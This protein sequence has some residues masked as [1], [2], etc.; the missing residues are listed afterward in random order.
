MIQSIADFINFMNENY[1]NRVAFRWVNYDT[2]ELI[3]KTFA[4]Y[5]ADIRRAAGHV[6]MLCPD[7]KGKHFAILAQNSYDYAV[8][9]FGI[10]LNG[11]VAVLLNPGET[12]E[13]I[14]YAAQLADTDIVLTDGSI[15]EKHPALTGNLPAK[16]Y[17]LFGYRDCEPLMSMTGK[18]A[19]GEMALIMFTSGT[20]GKC[21]GVMISRK[22]MF[23]QLDT[24][25]KINE[26][27]MRKYFASLGIEHF[28]MGMMPVSNGMFVHRMFHAAGISTLLAY[29]MFG[30]TSN[31][32][33]NL[34]YIYQ[35]LERMPCNK[36][37]AVPII[38]ELFYKD[39]ARG[40][41]QKLGILKEINCGAARIDEQVMNVFHENGFA[42]SQGYAL[43]ES[44]SGGTINPYTDITKIASVGKAGEG[45]EIRI[46]D[47]E[48]CMKGDS[49]MMGY[50]NNPEETAKVL[51]DGWLYTGD[52]GYLDDDGYLYLTGRKK[53]L[54]IL[55]GGENVSPEELEGLVSANEAVKEVIVKEK[56]GKVCAEIFCDADKQEEIRS[57][58]TEV[59]RKLAMYKRMTLVEFR[60]EPFPRTAS[61]KIKRHE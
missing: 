23:A 27:A 20:T 56:N 33:L 15:E 7:V 55:S 22:N 52:L 59:N 1:P 45:M 39:L 36:I 4:D 32:C 13:N 21:K 6:Q 30:I 60:E 42:I 28:S 46:E 48:V 14:C 26:M 12:E 17:S 53:N 11:A 34:R 3:E 37:S 57:F 49:I 51:R 16:S 35:D 61:G 40:K 19:Y 58:V 31:M 50:Y 54:I 18:E 29:G 41:K 44:F 47:G 2:D 8:N 10:M 25:L 9:L 24:F 5:T 43:T 38:V